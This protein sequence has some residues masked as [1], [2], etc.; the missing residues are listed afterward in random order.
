MTAFCT[1]IHNFIE[2][3]YRVTSNE[4][5][6]VKVVLQT[7]S[8]FD[9]DTTCA[10]ILTTC[11]HVCTYTHLTHMETHTGSIVTSKRRQGETHAALTLIH[12]VSPRQSSAGF[13][14]EET[15][16][17]LHTTTATEKTV[18]KESPHPFLLS[19]KHSPRPIVFIFISIL[20][21]TK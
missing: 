6:L 17:F 7:L 21:S 8:M 5:K 20:N 11:Q 14:S 4:D 13:N 15:F 18:H 16:G 19:Y 10:N 1:N 2:I 9:K 3:F 12:P